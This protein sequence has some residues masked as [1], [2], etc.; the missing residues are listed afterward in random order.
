MFL[1]HLRARESS[2]DVTCKIK[3]CKF[4]NLQPMPMANELIYNWGQR[5]GGL[6]KVRIVIGLHPN[7]TN[8]IFSKTSLIYH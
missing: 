8:F 1:F 2:I 6:L 5:I 3:K 7:K 4:Q